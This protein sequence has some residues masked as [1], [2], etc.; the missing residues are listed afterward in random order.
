MKAFIFDLDGTL[1]DTLGDIGNAC[2]K[3][4][5]NSG[6]PTHPLEAY[7]RM[8]GSGF[9]KLAE[10]ALPAE[11]GL[12]KGEL[13]KIVADM[14]TE[15]AANLMV[16]TRP[17]EGINET[18]ER[19]IASNAGVAVLSN[20][21]QPLTEKLIR[22]FFPEIPFF[23]I[24]GATPEMPLKPDPASTLRLLKKMNA[25]KQYS[26][27]IGDSDVDMKTALNA[28]IKGIGAAWGFRGAEELKKAGACMVIDT[29]LELVDLV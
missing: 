4:L 10:R 27:Y 14:R 1:L 19:L 17:Y 24:I 26:Y 8:V 9:E 3:V 5:E 7:R 11:S 28:G 20:K 6:F 22:S 29:P 25:V 21:P 12:T 16:R 15:Y 2:N 18:L 23:G 13:E